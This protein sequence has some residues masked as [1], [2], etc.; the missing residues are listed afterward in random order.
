MNAIAVVLVYLCVNYSFS[1]DVSNNIF[2][3]Y[4]TNY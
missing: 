2:K 3:D 4:V 1:L